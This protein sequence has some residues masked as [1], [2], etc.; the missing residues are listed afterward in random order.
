MKTRLTVTFARSLASCLASISI[1][2]VMLAQGAA[3]PA[4]AEVSAEAD[5]VLIEIR[6]MEL[7]LDAVASNVVT[8]SGE[9]LEFQHGPDGSSPTIITGP[10]ARIEIG[11]QE[12][13]LDTLELV[14]EN[15]D[16]RNPVLASERPMT[17]ISAPR[18]LTRI[19]QAASIAVGKQIPYLERD[20]DGHLQVRTDED[21][22]EG[23]RVTVEPE[24]H[25][26]EGVS[27]KRLRV[28]FGLLAGRE[29]LDG[30]PLEVG[31][32]I[33]SSV[34][35][36]GSVTIPPGHVAVIPMPTWDSELDPILVLIRA[37]PVPAVP[38]D[39]PNRT[40]DR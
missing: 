21:S 36:T 2:P 15:P 29:P 3:P 28:H 16:A 18:I 33:M 7:D 13:S 14:T 31:K 32:P 22:F 30:V 23:V 38:L 40:R 25:D 20:A 6:V 24:P 34:A 11:E 9:A 1:A 17:S 35:I 4:P 8:F 37:T 26:G 19:G 12:W 5:A 27:I 10:E 39:P